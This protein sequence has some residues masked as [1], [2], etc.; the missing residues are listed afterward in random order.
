[1]TPLRQFKGVPTEVI[2]KAEGKRFVSDICPPVVSLLII[3]VFHSL[4]IVTSI[5]YALSTS[6]SS[7]VAE[8]S[9]DT[10]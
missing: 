1:M 9:L 5:W 8:T 3:P 6:F 10:S 4:G 2:G 7:C